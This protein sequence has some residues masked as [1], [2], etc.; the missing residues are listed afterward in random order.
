[1]HFASVILTSILA[2]AAS[3]QD[4][5]T[6][7]A[8]SAATSSLTAEQQKCLGACDA[9]DVNCIAHCTPV[10]SPNE[11]NLTKLHECV[12]KCD[13]GDGTESATQ[14]YSNC[15]Q[16]YYDPEIGTP[17][18]PGAGSSSGSGS[19]SGSGDNSSGGDSESGDAT[20]TGSSA[21][22]TDSPGAAA[23]LIASSSF[24]L[25]GLLAAIAAF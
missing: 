23:G 1:M 13:Q 22:S 9:G 24:G 15:V 14:A 16:T 6:S 3:A 12:G 5:T 7:A 20:G 2:V 19:N 10:P 17:N 4:A 21:Q 25:C 18:Q 11:D 8:S